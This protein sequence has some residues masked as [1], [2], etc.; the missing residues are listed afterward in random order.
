MV[1]HI[2]GFEIIL[3]FCFRALKAAP[4]ILNI[5]TA[6]NGETL[7]VPDPGVLPHVY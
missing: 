5:T 3:L 2:R 4:M 7:I 1:Q 6:D